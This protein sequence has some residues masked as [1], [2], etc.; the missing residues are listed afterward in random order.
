MENSE[1]R[2][3]RLI[4]DLP[5]CF[6]MSFRNC[7]FTVARC[8]VA[9]NHDLLFSPCRYPA[10]HLE[11]LSSQHFHPLIPYLPSFRKQYHWPIPAMKHNQVRTEKG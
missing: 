4:G 3:N 6:K 11:V 9:S 5:D 7:G 8:R 2:A 1:D 10:A